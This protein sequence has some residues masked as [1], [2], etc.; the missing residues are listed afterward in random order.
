MGPLSLFWRSP[1]LAILATKEPLGRLAA[2]DCFQVGVKL[3]G[4]TRAHDNIGQVRVQCGG[5][6]DGN[7]C[8]GRFAGADAVDKVSSVPV[9]ILVIVVFNGELVLTVI[10]PVT[11]LSPALF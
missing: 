3:H 7:L 2:E 8:V 5:V 9:V 10:D 1:M 11:M 4:L 6:A